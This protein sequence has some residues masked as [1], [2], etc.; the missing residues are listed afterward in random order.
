MSP[1]LAGQIGWQPGTLP[2]HSPDTSKRM[3]SQNVCSTST[4]CGECQANLKESLEN[5][6]AR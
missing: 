2:A 6:A 5:D 1:E 3:F 4:L